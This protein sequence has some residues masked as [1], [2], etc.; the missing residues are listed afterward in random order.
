MSDGFTECTDPAGK[1]L[2]EDGLLD[3]LAEEDALTGTA[4]LDTILTRTER[5]AGGGEFADDMS[6]VLFAYDGPAAAPP[7]SATG[8]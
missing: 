3:M 5:F 6:A 4:L 7:M 8:A 2:G 1:I